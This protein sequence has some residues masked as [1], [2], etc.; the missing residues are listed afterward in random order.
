MRLHVMTKGAG[1][2]AHGL[3][4]ASLSV[5]WARSWAA[6][7]ITVHCTVDQELTIANP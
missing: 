4:P 2:L 6:M 5:A 7:Y 3:V 1:M